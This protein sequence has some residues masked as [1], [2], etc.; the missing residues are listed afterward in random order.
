MDLSQLYIIVA[1]SDVIKSSYYSY[2]NRGD[3]YSEAN[4]IVLILESK[5]L[6]NYY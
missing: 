6:Y 2:D 5:L 4:I 3:K 1:Y